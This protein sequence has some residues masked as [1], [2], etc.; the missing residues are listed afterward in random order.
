M[1]VMNRKN[2]SIEHIL[3]IVAFI[4]ALLIRWTNLGATPLSEPEAKL[5]LQAHQLMTNRHSIL[6]DS[7]I[8]IILTGLIFFVFGE[9]TFWARALP[10][11]MGSLLVW[12]PFSFRNL[13]GRKTALVMAF[14]LALDPSLVGLSRQANGIMLSISFSMLALALWQNRKF[15]LSVF[16][17]GLAFLGSISFIHGAI[18]LILVWLL[19][20]LLKS[21]NLFSTSIEL[22]QV[23]ERSDSTYHS[24]L[25]ALIILL[26]VST[27]FFLFPQV[28]GN[29]ANITLEYIKSWFLPTSSLSPLW[30]L[31]S[32]IVYQPLALIF[33]L[34]AALKGCLKRDGFLCFL[35]LWFVTILLL[36]IIYPSRQVSDLA[37]TLVPLWGL[38]SRIISQYI[39]MPECKDIPI[40]GQAALLFTLFT[41]MWMNLAGM[42]SV[43]FSDQTNQMRMN[44]LVGSLAL[45]VVTTILV[46]LGWS[47]QVAQKGLIWGIGSVLVLY[48]LSNTTGIVMHEWTK[49]IDLWIPYPSVSQADLLWKTLGDFAEYKNGRRDTLDVTVLIDSYSMKWI[50]KEWQGIRFNNKLSTDELPSV[51]ISSEEKQLTS[52]AT[53][54]RGQD[55]IW[56][57]YPLW[58]EGFLFDWVKWITFRKIPQRSERVILW[59]RNDLF[60]DSSSIYNNEPFPTYQEDDFESDKPVK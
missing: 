30:L 37:W 31:I 46:A 55:F 7:P 13:L 32:F 27:L 54:Y 47:L 3:Y 4:F 17:V 42:E 10:A 39:N 50:L 8:Y 56:R 1:Q 51:I 48:T 12:F 59:V 26:I 43:P 34:I 6:E 41:L 18:G 11:L 49:K 21:Y 40:A 52:L 58:Q 14:G 23:N 57:V 35:S 38:A 44:I 25:Q 24:L 22:P 60:P 45:G 53:S 16:C 36:D 2:L 20:K 29:I 33:G 28:I 5:A 15:I 19:W 9:S